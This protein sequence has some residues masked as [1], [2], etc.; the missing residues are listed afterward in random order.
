MDNQN[1]C[2]SIELAKL[3]VN[4]HK[5]NLFNLFCN[6]EYVYVKQHENNNNKNRSQIKRE[7]ENAL[8]PV[9]V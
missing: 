8:M 6:K 3:M 4:T 9:T 7:R 5:H 2:M 1:H